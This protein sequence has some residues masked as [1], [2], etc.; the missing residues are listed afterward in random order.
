[1]TPQPPPSWTCR[2]NSVEAAKDTHRAGGRC[3]AHKEQAAS[4]DAKRQEEGRGPP[5]RRLAGPAPVH[6]RLRSHHWSRLSA[7]HDDLDEFRAQ[8]AGSLAGSVAVATA[9]GGRETA[10][11][12]AL[13]LAAIERG[14]IDAS[15]TETA[16]LQGAAVALA[17]LAG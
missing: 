11:A 12:S 17:T 1:M 4:P 8:L 14:E 9:Q 15:A 6:S 2:A 7:R 13:A 5:C 3:A 16:R 10:D